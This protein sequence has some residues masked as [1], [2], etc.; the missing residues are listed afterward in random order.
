[1]RTPPPLLAACSLLCGGAAAFAPAS[2][3]PS[4]AAVATAA[5]ASAA[6]ARAPL[7]PPLPSW[8]SR[9]LL[10]QISEAPLDGELDG[11]GGSIDGGTMFTAWDGRDDEGLSPEGAVPPGEDLVE[12][13][14]RRLFDLESE[15]GLTAGSE[16]DE[17][18]LMY[19]LRKE[20]GDEDFKKIFEDPK[21]K[22]P[23]M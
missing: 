2:A 19:K 3:P 12:T 7:R 18:Q 11:W 15:D 20:L 21:V 22:G 10:L 1:M 8:R 6:A 14:L 13:D 17:L 4:G 5:A 16:M 9:R 23:S